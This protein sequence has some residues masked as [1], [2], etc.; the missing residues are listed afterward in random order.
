MLSE[1]SIEVISSAMRRPM[2]N[3]WLLWLMEI[4]LLSAG[5]VGPYRIGN[6]TQGNY[7]PIQ[8]KVLDRSVTDEE[9]E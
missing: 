8:Q 1:Y 7:A 6:F 5:K 4:R 3:T 9:G 2:M